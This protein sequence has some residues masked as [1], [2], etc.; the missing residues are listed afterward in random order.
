MGSH[1]RDYGWRGRCDVAAVASLAVSLDNTVGIAM[2]MTMVVAVALETQ[3]PW[4]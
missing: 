3:W 2:T 1:G 4:A